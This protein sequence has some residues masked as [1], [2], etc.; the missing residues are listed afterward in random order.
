MRGP[1]GPRGAR[2]QGAEPARRDGHRSRRATQMP[3]CGV[4]AESAGDHVV[5]CRWFKLGAKRGSALAMRRLAAA[6]AS[7]RGARRDV[8]NVEELAKAKEADLMEV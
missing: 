6:F 1:L 3:R 8:G 4:L 2:R 7:G 5:A